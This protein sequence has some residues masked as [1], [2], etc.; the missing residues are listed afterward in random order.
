MDE[1]RPTLGSQSLSRDRRP[2]GVCL[3]G[4]RQAAA[5]RDSERAPSRVKKT[6][7]GDPR[8]QQ[9]EGEV[10]AEMGARFLTTERG[11]RS[12]EREMMRMN[13]VVL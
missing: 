7:M 2:V 4:T 13:P 8:A 1:N 6:S 12:T 9:G 3:R 10:E 11:V 5:W